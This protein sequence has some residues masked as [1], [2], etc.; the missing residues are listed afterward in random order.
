MVQDQQDRADF[1]RKAEELRDDFLE[2]N[3]GNMDDALLA[4]CQ[5]LLRLEAD[6][7]QARESA[8]VG[9]SRTRREILDRG[10]K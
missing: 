6:L 5:V 1:F 2:Q 4:A 8:S 10:D 9:F 3:D 7:R